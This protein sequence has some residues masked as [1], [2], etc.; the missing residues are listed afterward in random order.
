MSDFKLTKDDLHHLPQL[1]HRLDESEETSFLAVVLL[2]GFTLIFLLVVAV[3]ILGISSP[4]ILPNTD[5]PSH[6]PT[7]MLV[8]PAA[9]LP[10]IHGIKA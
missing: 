7:S 8:M 2:S 9:Q 6:E 1:I 4:R 5:T 10:A 3:L